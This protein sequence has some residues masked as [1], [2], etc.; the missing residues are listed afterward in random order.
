M[1]SPLLR[2]IGRRGAAL[3]FFAALDTVWCVGLLSL[4]HPLPPVYAWMQEILPLW[5]WASYWG[6]VALI[7][8]FYAFRA[9]DTPAFVAAISIKVC[10]GLLSLFGW[11]SSAIVLGYLSAG[12]WLAFAAFVYLVAGGIPVPTPR[13]RRGAATW[14]RS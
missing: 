14:T 5:V 8:L 11:L 10:W 1:L 6:A 7:C 2:R 4:P 12:I 13:R 3:M 9:Y